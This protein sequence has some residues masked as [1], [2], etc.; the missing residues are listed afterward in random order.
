MAT[1]NNKNSWTYPEF[2]KSQTATD[3]DNNRNNLATQSPGEFTYG[4]YEKSDA[5]KQKDAN[6]EQFRTNNKPGDLQ[7]SYQNNL[8]DIINQIQ[9]GKKFSYDLNGDALYQ[10]YKDQYTLQGQQAMMDTMGQ[11]AAMTGGYGNSYAQTVGQ[12]TYQGYL[13]QLNDKVPELYKLALDKYNQD[14]QDLYDQYGMYSDLYDQEYRTQRDSVD[15]Y[16]TELKYLTDDARY[17]G[18][19]EYNMYSDKYD[20]AYNLHS[21]KVNAWKDALARADDEY[22]NQV[23]FEYGTYSDDRGLSYEQNRNSVA[24]AQYAEKLAYQKEQDA[25]ANEWKQKEFDEAVRQFDVGQSSKASSGGSSN[26]G[27]S[28]EDAKAGY[29]NGGVAESGI[30]RM[31]NLLGV[32]ADGKWGPES[33]KAAKAKYGT[34]N[35]AELYKKLVGDAFDAPRETDNTKKFQST[36]HPESQHDAVMRH[37][38]G[39]YR[40]YV[41]EQIEKADLSDS[42]KAY[43]ISQYGI[44]ESDTNYKNR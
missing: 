16:W 4:D 14:R 40:Q 19:Q 2:K 28:T 18:E 13:Q 36:L 34:T 24:D 23:K 27:G 29:D 5:A 22:W 42:E 32:T 3:L 25:L 21:D 12:Q 31:Q 35:A 33:Q 43:L 30:K 17:F 11:A 7:F 41:A 20:R 38:Y 9:N 15:D 8:N 44:T 1:T 39:S 10:Q 6:V 37:M 26:S